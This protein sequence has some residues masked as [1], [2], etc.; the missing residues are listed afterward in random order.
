MKNWL[1]ALVCILV[2]LTVLMPAA[3][4]A[5]TPSEALSTAGLDAILG[6]NG[7]SGKSSGSSKSTSS[8]S[9]LSGLGKLDSLMADKKQEAPEGGKAAQIAAINLPFSVAI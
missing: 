5:T 1:K 9:S 3:M 8:G 2:L 4:A 6:K 7:S